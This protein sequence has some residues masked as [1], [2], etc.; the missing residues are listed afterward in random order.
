MR[1][2]YKLL[3]ILVLVSVLFMGF[4]PGSGFS[5]EA[6]ETV[7]VALTGKYPPFSF[8]SAEGELI[9]FDVDVSKEIA[10]RLDR[11]LELVTTEW[12]G[13]LAGLLV[14]RYDAVIGSMA[15]TPERQKQVD[16]SR[17]YYISGAQVFI[18]REDADKYS[19]IYD[20]EGK[21]MGVVLGETFEHYLRNNH[22]EIEAVTYK[23]TFD[24][25]QDMQNRRID[26][27]L[28][29]RLVGL[30]QIEMA[31]MPFV[32]RGNLL[33]EERMGIPVTKDNIEL[34]RLIN[35]ALHSM[36]RDG[37]IE[38]IYEKWFGEG[39]QPVSAVIEPSTVARNLLRGFSITLFVAAISIGLGFVLSI[40]W[41]VGLNTK[42][43][44][45]KPVLR[46]INDFLR[47]TPLLIQLF[48]VYFGAPQIGINLTPIQASIFT[49]TINC[50][51][52]M[53]E[54]IRSG[55]MAVSSGQK[56]AGRA[57]GLSKI[58]VFRYVIWPQ[59]FRV[60]IPPLMNSV[61]ALIKD[62]ALIAIIAVGE[63]IREAQSIISVTYNP[64]RYY[65]IAGLLF[66]AFTFPLMK[67]SGR[68][69][70]KIKERGYANA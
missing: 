58:Q 17:P 15:I 59:A 8:F 22:P 63:V 25:F 20:L 19:S 51:A 16:F 38:A 70:K 28:T 46:F 32:A 49:L 36:E 42:I 2:L 13:I 54:V 23:S 47:S 29:D 9:G 40:P 10:L 5:S 39:A 50:S 1:L 37:T 60:A 56:Y 53:A 26:G 21:R 66:F 69:E 34:L 61:V 33:Y 7:T 3:Y 52:Y 67:L 30:Y 55:L 27:F 6:K 41:G 24:I 48:F 35:S 44:V 14:G 43:A 11:E 62:T 18:H 12:D 65:F 57:L 45:L 31:D 68:L 64:M 4:I